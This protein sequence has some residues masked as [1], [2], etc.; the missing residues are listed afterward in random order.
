M[1]PT[2]RS[3]HMSLGMTSQSDKERI[4]S[5]C[6]H[7]VD[8]NSVGQVMAVGAVCPS[9]TNSN[10][11]EYVT[12]PNCKRVNCPWSCQIAIVQPNVAIDPVSPLFDRSTTHD[13]SQFVMSSHVNYRP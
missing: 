3:N 10:A 12:I 1:G 6:T 9:L 4:W 8:R 7:C 11:M 5:E 2:L 13:R